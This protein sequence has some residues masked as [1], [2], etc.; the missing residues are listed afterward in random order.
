MTSQRDLGPL[1]LQAITL[2]YANPDSV[3]SHLR[4]FSEN[5]SIREYQKVFESV[6]GECLSVVHVALHEAEDDYEKRRAAIPEHMLGRC[7]WIPTVL[8]LR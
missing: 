1:T 8:S 6:S 5:R 2:A 3:P 4:V 7:T